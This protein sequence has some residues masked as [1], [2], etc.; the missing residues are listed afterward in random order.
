MRAVGFDLAEYTTKQVAL[1]DI[2]VALCQG[3]VS[4]FFPQS[5]LFL[6]T[7]LSLFS[8]SIA[9]RL[10]HVP[11]LWVSRRGLN[12]LMYLGSLLM[13]LFL[14]FSKEPHVRR[15]FGFH[16]IRPCEL[17]QF[18]DTKTIVYLLISH[19][20][21]P[22]Y[23]GRTNAHL[24]RGQEHLTN[25]LNR[26]NHQMLYDA[27]RSMGPSKFFLVPFRVTRDVESEEKALINFLN[28]P[29]NVAHISQR[30]RGRKRPVIALRESFRPK[31]L[32]RLLFSKTSFRVYNLTSGHESLSGLILESLLVLL[33]SA[34]HI[35]VS[36]E[37]S[38]SHADLTSWRSV[39]RQFGDSI[40]LAP[41]TFCGPLRLAV[42]DIRFLHACTLT[43]ALCLPASNPVKETIRKIVTRPDIWYPKL[44]SMTLNELISLKI[45]AKELITRD[46]NA[47]AIETIQKVLL[48]KYGLTGLPKLTMRLPFTHGQNTGGLRHVLNLVLVLCQFSQEVR[49][50]LSSNFRVV[51]TRRESIA[52]IFYNNISFAKRFN[53]LTTERCFCYKLDPNTIDHEILL[54]ESLS[55]DAKIVLSQNSKN[56]PHPGELD[57]FD[58]IK[59]AFAAVL[60]QILRFSRKSREFQICPAFLRTQEQKVDLES[61]FLANDP[62]FSTISGLLRCS[63]KRRQNQAWVPKSLSL[64][65][66]KS[67]KRDL[68]GLIFLGLDK[69][70]GKTAVICPVKMH[71]ILNRVFCDD[72]KHYEMITERT[73]EQI[74]A[75]IKLSFVQN[76]WFS[77]A[78]LSRAVGLPYGYAVPK[79]KDLSRNRPI[80]SYVRHPLKNVFRV[81]QKAIMFIIKNMKVAHFTLNRTQDLLDK[82]QE[83]NSELSQTFGSQTRLVPFSMDIKEMFTELLHSAVCDAII[84]VINQANDLTRSR[85]VRVPKDKSLRCSFGKS[86]NKFET[87]HITFDQIFEVVQFDI[88]N[89]FFTVGD[90]IFRQVNGVPIGGILSTAEAIATCAV[91]E[92]KWLASL[93][94][95]VRYFKA[96][97]YVDDVCGVI[98]YQDQSNDSIFKAQLMLND[99]REN[100]YPGGLLLKEEKIENGNF[101]FLETL[102]TVSESSISA[103]FF[104]KNIEQICETGSQKF[105]TLQSSFSYSS[106]AAKLGVLVARLFAIYNNTSTSADLFK[107]VGLFFIELRVLGYGAKM[108]KQACTRMQGHVGGDIWSLIIRFLVF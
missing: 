68:K 93:G 51:N 104:S 9:E 29:L 58:E 54:P 38:D 97:R 52:D 19:E 23:V 84:F 5:V 89:A 85:F 41:V 45:R 108:L 42:N 82:F 34:P 90:H 98:A 81:A 107:A 43:L 65:M 103:C 56:I 77:V 22:F 14:M 10:C 74:L 1:E 95:N 99:F 71:Q 79:A 30:K 106:K 25:S 36:W 69:N 86:S 49:D 61:L 62:M 26:G 64:K 92:Y 75:G 70:V 102:A 100:C 16:T 47:K 27:L 3:L 2:A 67:V 21:R 83:F 80:V 12:L 105:F 15:I 20:H 91:A 24:R 31:K 46:F 88:K 50:H 39:T 55:G 8:E 33:P 6:P 101:R 35:T 73:S 17:I 32:K 57:T 37:S 53:A 18:G 96:V 4:N 28:P 44:M 59:T 7:A 76:G 78:T 63:A 48:R 66:A 94:N 60:A 72:T 87:D 13:L 40:I 11:R